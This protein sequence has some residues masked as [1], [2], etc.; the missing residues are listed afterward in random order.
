MEY[1]QLEWDALAAKYP[2]GT[3]VAGRVI[4]QRPF[5]VFVDLEALSDVVAL[6]ELFYFEVLNVEPNR[7]LNFPDD[8]PGVGSQIATKIL[9][10]S[11]KPDQVRLTQ[12][13]KVEPT[14]TRG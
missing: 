3:S 8:Y 9:R 7:R 1:T 6:L 14:G 5:G 12:L 10:W 4:I 2:P 13:V 11:L